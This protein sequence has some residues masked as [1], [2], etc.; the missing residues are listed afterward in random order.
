MLGTRSSA[1]SKYQSN[2]STGEECDSEEDL[3]PS[4][5][6]GDVERVFFHL[7]NAKVV[8][9]TKNS[10]KTKRSAFIPEGCGQSRL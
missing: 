5:V 2:L 4:L 1:S 9:D 8:D 3:D 6:D 10:R 7:G